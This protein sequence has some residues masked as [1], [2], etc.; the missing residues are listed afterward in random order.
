MDPLEGFCLL[1]KSARGRA[2]VQ[3]IQEATAAPGLFAFGELLDMPNVQQLKNG[4]FAQSFELL[5]LFAHGTWSDYK[6]AA[7]NL[8]ALNDAQALKLKQLTVVSLAEGASMLPYETLMS[9]LEVPTVRQLEDLLINDCMYTGIVRGK[10]DQQKR[11]LEVYYAAGRDIRPGQLDKMLATL[12]SWTT[13]SQQ[14]LSTIEEKVKW[15]GDTTA[16]RVQRKAKLEARV[17]ELK[18]HIK[19]E[20]DRGQS[21][22]LFDVGAADMDLTPMDEDRIGGRSKR[23]R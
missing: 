23:R 7:S 19:P 15:A 17:E 21:D 22:G 2:A 10:L 6:A 20:V 8:P 11:C 18:K 4:E 16:V 13:T 3:I 12:K 5:R 14:L 9:Q 1:A